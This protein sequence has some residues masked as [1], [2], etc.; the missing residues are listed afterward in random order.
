MKTIFVDLGEDIRV[1]NSTSTIT[2]D[3]TGGNAPKKK[4][5]C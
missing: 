2:I 1:M 4:G 3:K 5:G